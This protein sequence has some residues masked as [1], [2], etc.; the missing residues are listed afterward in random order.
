MKTLVKLDLLHNIWRVEV[1]F[2]GG[3]DFLPTNPRTI[4]HNMIH[5]PKKG[6]EMVPL[7]IVRRT[8]CVYISYPTAKDNIILSGTISVEKNSAKICLEARQDGQWE[9]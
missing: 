7:R 3:S 6:K 4:Q 9:L 2:F 5:L 1:I 8:R